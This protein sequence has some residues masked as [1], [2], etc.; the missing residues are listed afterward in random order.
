MITNL[1]NDEII[2]HTDNK[3]DATPLE[4]ELAERLH[5][6]IV[7]ARGGDIVDALDRLQRAMVLGE[8]Q[9]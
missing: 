1:T 6:A 5:N 2:L 9:K 8:L 4:R 3:T 7:A